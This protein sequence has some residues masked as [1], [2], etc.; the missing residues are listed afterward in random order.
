M[1]FKID[2]QRLF[3]KAV[4]SLFSMGLTSPAT[5]N[6]AVRSIL[7]G[8]SDGDINRAQSLA[9]EGLQAHLH[10]V[11]RHSEGFLERFDERVSY[12]PVKVPF[13]GRQVVPIGT[14]PGMDL[15]AEALEPFSYLFGFQMPGPVLFEPREMQEAPF[16]DD[17]TRGDLFV[18]P[19]FPSRGLP[20]FVQ[21]LQAYR[22]AGGQAVILPSVLGLPQQAGSQQAARRQLESMLVELAPDSDGFVWCPAAARSSELMS[23]REFRAT[24]ELMLRV[25]GDRLKLVEMPPYEPPNRDGWLSLVSA[26]LDGGGD[27]L[28][29]VCGMEVPVTRLPKGE[30]WPFATAVLCGR[31]LA[32]YRQRAIEDARRA[33]PQALIVASGGFY[34]R[35]EAFRACQFANLI[36]DTE[37]FT[38]Y[39]PGLS[40]TMLKKLAQRLSFLQRE[41]E[42]A[43]ETLVEYQQQFWQALQE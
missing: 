39:G 25:A 27:G 18:P 38:R 28:V 1:S 5:F 21:N 36:A 43:A 16:V 37:G 30:R 32:S 17:P 7:H 23:E 13:A 24:A 40:R 6:G 19:E 11:K 12:E 35:D 8:H 14:A 31:S 29:A 20:D 26:F 41:G 3:G 15:N 22:E 10:V 42:T 34:S 33:F 4:D 9:I 2:F